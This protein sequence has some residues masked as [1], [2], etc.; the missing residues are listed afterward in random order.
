MKNYLNKDWPV[1]LIVLGVLMI[2]AREVIIHFT[3][4]GPVSTDEQTGQWTAPSLY[5]DHTLEGEDREKVIYGEELIANTAKY[6]GPKGKVLQITNGMNCQNCH[7]QAGKLPWGN[8]YSAVNSTYPK[9]RD[10]SGTVETISRRINDCFERSLN[11]KAIDTL[12]K[13][14]QSII[15]YIKWLGQDVEKGTKPESSGIRQLDYLDRAADPARGR[16]VFMARCQSCHGANGAGVMDPGG[17]QYT[18][19]PL[20]GE[21][22]Y[23]TGA[24]LFR[25][26]RIAGYVKDNMPFNQSSH[27]EPAL[28]DEEAWD[29]AAFVNSQ[30]RPE[31]D[32]AG[33]WPDIS[34][35]PI[36]HPFGPYD[37]G[38]DE[39]QHKYGPF[40][41]I[42]EARKKLKGETA[43][44]QQK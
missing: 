42:I 30:P 22:S 19:P 44:A 33:D 17:L 37:D 34:K 12:G 20:W 15:A 5:Y 26:S 9:F 43:L 6:F 31:K 41:P 28:S 18:Y 16:L 13:E 27:A 21:N 36:D 32:L 39:R 4:P 35:K 38:F 1:Y 2:I 24:G 3:G 40:L 29:V 23:N 7:L 10:R 14:M 25:L 11:G 8:N